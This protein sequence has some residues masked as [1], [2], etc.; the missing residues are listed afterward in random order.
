M[1]GKIG[2]KIGRW[3]NNYIKSYGVFTWETPLWF[4]HKTGILWR[5]WPRRIIVQFF[6]SILAQIDDEEYQAARGTVI[7]R[8]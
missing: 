7:Y 2:I 3:L 1:M 5:F 4:F 8:K 6:I